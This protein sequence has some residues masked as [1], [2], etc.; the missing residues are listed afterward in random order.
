MKMSQT[1][2]FDIGGVLIEWNPRHLY[3][4]LFQGDDISMEHFLTHICS[5]T[6]NQ[7]QD[8]GRSFAEGVAELSARYP[9]L[10][11]LIAAYDERWEEMV[12]GAIEDSVAL[13]EALQRR[14][15]PIYGL[16][17]FSREKF[18]LTQ[19]RF[20]F[21]KTFDGLVVSAQVGLVKPDPAIYLHL[22]DS[23]KLQAKNCIFIDDSRIN[24]EAAAKLGMQ[25]IRFESPA[26]LRTSL[27][28]LGVL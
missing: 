5:D 2:I 22:L 3:R 8:A 26:Q 24:V 12:P 15:C 14:G 27:S 17:N 11:D 13:F 10:A 9:D 20:A 18:A 19:R 16:T 25:A 4:K 28:E 1:L 7:M 6:W 23:Y 21:L